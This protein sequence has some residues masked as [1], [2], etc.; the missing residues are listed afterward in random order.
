MF[1]RKSWLRRAP[2]PLLIFLFRQALELEQPTL[3]LCIHS[4]GSLYSIWVAPFPPQHW[5]LPHPPS[6]QQDV[7]TRTAWLTLVEGQWLN[8]CTIALPDVVLEDSAELSS[9]RASLG[10]L[11]H[12]FGEQGLPSSY[13]TVQRQ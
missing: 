6:Y 8:A 4:V 11:S 5:H 9:R 13:I 3:R 12:C 1:F 10:G 2:G 7:Q